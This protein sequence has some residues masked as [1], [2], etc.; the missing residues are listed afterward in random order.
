MASNIDSAQFNSDA[1]FKHFIKDRSISEILEK[2][3]ETYTEIRT[4]DTELQT[5]VYENYSKFISATDVIKGIKS[6]FGEIDEELTH[7]E[8]SLSTV[9]KSFNTIDD[10]LKLKWKE[11]KKLDIL[12]KDLKKLKLLQDLP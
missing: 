10:K 12:E 1:F 5:L 9:N 4:L 11:I 3:N 6:N 8:A 2:N 7:L